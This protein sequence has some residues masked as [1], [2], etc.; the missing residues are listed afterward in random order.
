[1][2]ETLTRLHQL[3]SRR[4]RAVNPGH[5]KELNGSI[6]DEYGSG[7]GLTNDRCQQSRL[8]RMSECYVFIG[9]KTSVGGLGRDSHFNTTEEVEKGAE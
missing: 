4:P 9:C 2:G 3:G 6:Q 8:D 1:M 7:I 5:Y